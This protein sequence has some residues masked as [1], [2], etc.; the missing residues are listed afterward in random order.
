MVGIRLGVLV[1]SFQIFKPSQKEQKKLSNGENPNSQV[2]NYMHF[3]MKFPLKLCHVWRLALKYIMKI[4]LQ[5]MCV[6][7]WERVK[8]RKMCVCV[9]ARACSLLPPKKGSKE[10]FQEH[11]IFA[12]VYICG[13]KTHDL[14]ARMLKL[15]AH[16]Q[17]KPLN[18]LKGISTIVWTKR[19]FHK[20]LRFFVHKW[21]H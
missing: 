11:A 20:E 3:K 4:T 14:F 1:L 12:Q 9:R 15:K 13:W 19:D 7:T 2:S 10:C 21:I 18:L 17:P 8:E 16:A 6:H 5:T